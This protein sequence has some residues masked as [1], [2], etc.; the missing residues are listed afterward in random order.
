MKRIL[1]LSCLFL[2]SA[3]LLDASENMQLVYVNAKSGLVIRDNPGKE[4]K[5]LATLPYG[6]QLV[7]KKESGNKDT[8]DGVKASWYMIEYE[9]VQGWV[10]GG[11]LS[12]KPVSKFNTVKIINK[13]TGNNDFDSFVTFLNQL[14][15]DNLN[16]LKYA[17]DYYLL[18]VPKTEENR[19]D[20]YFDILDSYFIAYCEKFQENVS[21]NKL[22]SEKFK[23]LSTGDGS[24]DTSKTNDFLGKLKNVGLDVFYTEGDGYLVRNPEYLKN[25]CSKYLSDAMKEYLSIAYLEQSKPFQED[26]GLTISY[27]ELSKRLVRIEEFL[28]KYPAMLHRDS[29]YQLYIV[30]TDSLMHG[31]DNT[32][33]YD[34]E[35][36]KMEQGAIDAYT[37]MI[38]SYPNAKCTKFIEEYYNVLNKN[39]FIHTDEVYNEFNYEKIKKRASID[40]K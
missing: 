36:K 13:Y 26:A 14:N 35:T 23:T 7:K 29:A 40:F 34:Y 3:S 12:D 9:N 17:L 38:K 33:S 22:Y 6:T 19:R 24:V 4:N 25:K 18:S 10:F 2:L 11:M 32:Q 21:S 27:S 5:K 16:S 37:E 39:N 20:E 1:F 15:A 8:I 31:L 30:Y 28:G